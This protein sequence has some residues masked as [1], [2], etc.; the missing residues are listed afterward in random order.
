[1]ARFPDIFTGGY[2][3]P[4]LRAD[5][6]AAPSTTVQKS[7]DALTTADIPSTTELADDFEK[8][9]KDDCECDKPKRTKLKS[10][11]QSS[12]E[13]LET[14]AKSCTESETQAKATEPNKWSKRLEAL[15]E[16]RGASEGT[17]AAG[18]A[19]MAKDTGRIL[20]LQRALDKTDPASGKF[21]FPGGHL[22]P[23]ETPFDAAK[24]EWE[25]ETGLTL[26]KGKEAGWYK[27]G[28]YEAF[29][30][31]I[32][33]ESQ[34]EI[35]PAHV[36]REVSSPDDPQG[37]W[38]ETAIWFDV[39]DMVGNKTIRQELLD[40]MNDVLTQVRY[41][42]EEHETP[43]TKSLSLNEPSRACQKRTILEASRAMLGTC[44]EPGQRSEPSE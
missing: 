38:N 42:R 13:L 40:A 3:K 24:R 10:I 7:F 43:K 23:D 35:N 36:D 17:I 29:F 11:L 44:Q 34:L 37:Q 27:R 6:I 41:I 33:K 30:Y 4:G 9:M 31:L 25:E 18:L 39:S 8:C 21:E 2:S 12:R 26:P 14:T 19:V 22:E 15:K 32:D 28:I 5:F 16:R 1:M 20:L